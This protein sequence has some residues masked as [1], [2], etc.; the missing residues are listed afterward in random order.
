MKEE[1]EVLHARLLAELPHIIKVI[2]I[3]SV[4]HKAKYDALLTQG[5]TEAQ[6]LELCKI[7]P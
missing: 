3:T 6:A 2:A 1:P 7:I 5:F 4:M